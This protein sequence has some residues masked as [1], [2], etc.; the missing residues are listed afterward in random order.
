M[1]VAGNVEVD[2]LKAN[3]NYELDRFLRR[4][5]FP[6]HAEMTAVEP[7]AADAKIISSR[8]PT[9]GGPMRPATIGIVLHARSGGVP[10]QGLARLQILGQHV[11]RGTTSRRR[12][13]VCSCVGMRITR[14]DPA[15]RGDAEVRAPGI[16]RGKN[17]TPI[18]Q[19]SRSQTDCP[20]G[21]RI[22]PGLVRRWP[23][24]KHLPG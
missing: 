15:R 20:T 10:G 5:E 1:A 21:K 14:V 4:D 16:Q 24:A 22:S 9:H 23:C 3:Q 13:P 6:S 2:R 11:G 7:G 19:I 17:V 18:S 12:N 8:T